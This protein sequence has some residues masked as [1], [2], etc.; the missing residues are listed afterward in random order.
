MAIGEVEGEGPG[1][2]GTPLPSAEALMIRPYSARMA[3]TDLVH[4]NCGIKAIPYLSA[5]VLQGSEAI[6][7][8]PET[9]SG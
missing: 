7:P 6:W 5:Q 3:A 4:R 1:W 9:P 8:A 2:V